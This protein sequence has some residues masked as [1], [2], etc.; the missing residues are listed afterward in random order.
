MALN[1]YDSEQKVYFSDEPAYYFGWQ[2]SFSGHME[3][4]HYFSSQSKKDKYVKQATKILGKQHPG[5][6]YYHNDVI[7]LAVFAHANDS[8]S[9]DLSMELERIAEAC[10]EGIDEEAL[11]DTAI[12]L[13]ELASKIENA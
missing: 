9:F 4:I 7:A 2:F 13:G 1:V 3:D 12:D 8:D 5:L 11:Y 6:K 10:E